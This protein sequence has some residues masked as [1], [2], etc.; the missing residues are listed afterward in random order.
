M[1]TMRLKNI[2][3]DDGKWVVRFEHDN[4]E[5]EAIDQTLGGALRLIWRMI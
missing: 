1:T 2:N 3:Y 4:Q 5:Q